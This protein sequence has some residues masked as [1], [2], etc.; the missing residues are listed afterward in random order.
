MFKGKDGKERYPLVEALKKQRR[1]QRFRFH[2]P[3]HVTERPYRN[4]Y[5]Y[6]LTEL[7]GL[8]N[9]FN[10]ED[11]IA[12]SQKESARFFKAYKT[13][14]LVNG[15]SAGLISALWSFCRPGD[16]VLTGSNFHRSVASA[17][18]M[19]GAFPDFIPMKSFLPEIPLNIDIEETELLMSQKKYKVLLITSPSYWGITPDLKRLC[20]LAGRHGIPVIVDEAHGGHFIFHES[21]PCSASEAG[22]HIWVNSAH[23]TLG[24]LTAGAFLHC[25]KE[26]VDFNRL[27]SALAMVQTS[28]PS[29]AVMASLELLRKDKG[30]WDSALDVAFYGRK[31]L[32]NL[33]GFSVLD[34]GSFAPGFSLDPLRITLIK[35]KITISSFMVKSLLSKGYGIEIEMAGYGFLTLLVHR[36]HTLYDMDTLYDALKDIEKNYYGC[37][38]NSDEYYPASS[39]RKE[40]K[41]LPRSAVDMNWRSLFLRQ[42]VGRIAA[43]TVTAFPPGIPALIPGQ[44]I[45]GE[46]I[47]AIYC[48]LRQGYSF[49]GMKMKP[50]PMVDVVVEE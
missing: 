3:S 23:K 47:K 7:S 36:G 49:T 35:E 46:L 48:D 15:S 2:V 8:D 9:L 25:R 19:S 34:S 43:T 40:V 30:N 28:S 6:D 44:L 24:A 10:P 39:I 13:Y 22:A 41:I 32:G 27:N 14:Y 38:E 1:S 50:E 11:V 31:K 29:Y 5:E 33:N 12:D 26:E 18:V 17:L 45:T 4:C 42:A 21:F 16:A 20:R 37:D